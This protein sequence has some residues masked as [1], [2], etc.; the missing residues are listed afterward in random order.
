MIIDNKRVIEDWYDHVVAQ[1]G[2]AGLAPSEAKKQLQGM[3][4]SDALA[5]PDGQGIAIDTL[6]GIAKLAIAHAVDSIRNSRNSQKSRSIGDLHEAIVSGRIANID[7]L[8]LDLALPIGNGKDKALGDWSHEDL[9]DWAEA[10]LNSSRAAVVAHQRNVES[11][12]WLA[13]L[14]EGGKTV[15]DIYNESTGRVAA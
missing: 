3:W 11:A 10:S 4:V 12:N 6:Q 15:R 14:L 13:P 2:A 9:E 5:S 7:P 1:A 8:F